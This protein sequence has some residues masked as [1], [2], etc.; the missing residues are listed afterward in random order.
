MTAWSTFADEQPA[1]VFTRGNATRHE[2]RLAVLVAFG[3]PISLHRTAFEI[4]SN[5]PSN[6]GICRLLRSVEK[7]IGTT[8]SAFVDARQFDTDIINLLFGYSSPVKVDD[9]AP[10]NSEWVVLESCTVVRETQVP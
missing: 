9:V 7:P 5:D 6:L 2:H 8:C 3:N 4:V 10:Q 1:I